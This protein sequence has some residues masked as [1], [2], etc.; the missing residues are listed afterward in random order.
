MN[1]I[2]MSWLTQPMVWSHL[3]LLRLDQSPLTPA[4]EHT[5][6]SETAWELVREMVL[7]QCGPVKN[8]PVNVR[9][10]CMQQN[11]IFFH[12]L[13]LISNELPATNQLKLYTHAVTVILCPELFLINGRVIKPSLTVGSLAVHQCNSGFTLT[14]VIT[15]QCQRSGEW[16]ET[17]PTCTRKLYYCIILLCYTIP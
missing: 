16:S 4:I 5:D 1:A 10:S 9:W 14:G 2:L 6:W 8:Q 3:I 15:R 11:L 7:S 17:P 12:T 13:H